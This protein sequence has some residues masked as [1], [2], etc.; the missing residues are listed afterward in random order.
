M[1]KEVEIICRSGCKP[2]RRALKLN[3]DSPVEN[4]GQP[5]QAPA[6][7]PLSAKSIWK[8]LFVPL[9]RY[10]ESSNIANRDLA[11]DSAAAANFCSLDASLC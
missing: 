1:E 10:T 3:P 2:R 5:V 8:K 6:R 4:E 11:A 7:C 9:A